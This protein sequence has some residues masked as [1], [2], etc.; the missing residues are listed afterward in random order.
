MF[1]RDPRS[2]NVL[3]EPWRLRFVFYFQHGENVFYVEDPEFGLIKI[4]WSCTLFTL[5]TTESKRYKFKTFASRQG[6]YYGKDSIEPD[7]LFCSRSYKVRS[8]P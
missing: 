6:S 8:I 2:L 4:K 1:V 7:P 5:R 3:L